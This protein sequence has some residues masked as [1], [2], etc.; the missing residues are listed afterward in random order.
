[1]K[2]HKQFGLASYKCLKSLPKNAGVSKQDTFE[3]LDEICKEC[4]TYLLLKKPPPS[5]AVGLPLAS[6][7]NE[8]VAMDLHELGQ[9]VWYL[10]LIDEF[11]CLNAASL[12]HTKAQPVI[13]TEFLHC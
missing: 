2:L 1:M 7:F 6:D 3:I 12:V 13:M 9:S 11:T 10:H 5:P 8:T 4:N